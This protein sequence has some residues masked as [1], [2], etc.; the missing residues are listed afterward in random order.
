MFEKCAS[1]KQFYSRLQLKL[2]LMK[3]EEQ[4]QCGEIEIAI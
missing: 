1:L 4:I 2:Y 3:L